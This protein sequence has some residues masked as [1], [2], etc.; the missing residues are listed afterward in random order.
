MK[1]TM[2]CTLSSLAIF[3]FGMATVLAQSERTKAKDGSGVFG[4]KDIPKFLGANTAVVGELYPFGYG[5]S[6]TTFEYINLKVST[7]TQQTQGEIRVSVDVTNT[8]NRKGEEV[9]QLYMKDLVS[10][11][12]VYE[13]RLRGFE[14][15][16]LNPGETK[17]IHFKLK[18]T[19][20]ELLDI[21]MHWIVEAG[22]FEVLVGSSSE[23]IRLTGAFE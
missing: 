11:V 20:L 4:Y 12:T 3:I 7:E 1:K 19:D 17:T 6:Y 23:D 13:T 14:R 18:P 21:D 16:A 8:G 5:L 9:M 15:V 10:S 2:T 22:K